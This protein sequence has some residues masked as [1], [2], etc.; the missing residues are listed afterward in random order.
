MK[1]YRV[2]V[3]VNKPM[4]VDYLVNAET[5]QEARNNYDGFPIINEE[6]YVGNDEDEVIEVVE[7]K[8]NE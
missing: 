1:K 3:L 6:P 5:E 8:E 4:Y 7:V 2:T